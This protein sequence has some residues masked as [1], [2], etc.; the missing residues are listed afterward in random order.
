MV[1]KHLKLAQKP[2]ISV[3][4]KKI[5]IHRDSLYMWNKNRNDK[6]TERYHK[7]LRNRVMYEIRK[8]KSEYYKNYFDQHKTIMKKN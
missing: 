5:I 7:R 2:W 8:C 3:K 6:I 1:K 4:I